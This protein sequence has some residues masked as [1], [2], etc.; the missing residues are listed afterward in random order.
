[1]KRYYIGLGFPKGADRKLEKFTNFQN[2]IPH[3]LD[4]HILTERNYRLTNEIKTFLQSLRLDKNDIFE[5]R[6]DDEGRVDRAVYKMLLNDRETINIVIMWDGR[7]KTF[8][9]N[10]INDVH[11]TL[12]T[13]IYDTVAILKQIQERIGKLI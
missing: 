1:M 12:D 8:W 6:E 3:Q 11:K 5:Y 2:S 10:N 9:L 7:I 4:S 13:S